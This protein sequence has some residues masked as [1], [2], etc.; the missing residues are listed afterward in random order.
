[1]HCPWKRSQELNPFAPYTIKH[2]NQ[3]VFHIISCRIIK[4][5]F[6]STSPPWL[7]QRLATSS[8]HRRVNPNLPQHHHGLQPPLLCSSH[9]SSVHQ[10]HNTHSSLNDRSLLGVG[11]DKANVASKTSKLDVR[12]DK[13][14][15]DIYLLVYPTVCFMKKMRKNWSIE[16]RGI[17]GENGNW[18][19]LS[20][21]APPMLYIRYLRAIWIPT[22]W[23][24]S[25]GEASFWIAKPP[26]SSSGA[27]KCSKGGRTGKVLIR[28]K[29]ACRLAKPFFR[30]SIIFSL[31][32]SE[33]V[34][35]KE[36]LRSSNGMWRGIHWQSGSQAI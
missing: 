30:N 25:H 35:P 10:V 36:C 15:I 14:T 12:I 16:S 9:R 32:L 4:I 27:S 3:T 26:T 28:S 2:P 20:K 29:A 13:K 22:Y 23:W 6:G 34:N 21:K 33:A 1:M 5:R 19:L 24:S 17:W 8:F 31:D 7:Q 18:V 11:H